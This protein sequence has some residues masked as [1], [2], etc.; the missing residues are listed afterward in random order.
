[1]IK[2]KF[3]LLYSI[4]VLAFLMESCHS[5]QQ[6][7]A[8]TQSNGTSLQISTASTDENTLTATE[9]AAGW[10]LL[11]DGKTNT[12]WRGAYQD[13]FPTQGWKIENG[14]LIVL[15][16]GGAEANNGGDIITT[17][18]YDNFELTLEAKLTPGA[19]SGVKY[20]VTERLPRS[21]GSAIGL[22]FQVL[23]DDLHPDAKKG[24]KG[25][26]T[27]GSLYDLIPAQNK[28]ARP[29]GEWNQ[30]RLVSNHQHV[31]HWLNGTKVVD[32]ERGNPAFR[33]LV[34]DSKYKDYENFGE[35]AKGHILLQDHGDEVH[36]RN[37]KLK[38]L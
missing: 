24:K 14:E 2:I 6:V 28:T 27:V 7:T 8:T 9:R 22:E 10:K 20:F 17:E 37:I 35:A 31:E 4:L 16:S 29:I 11:F 38:P 1:M 32:F 23:D 19:N 3:F 15:K 30:I 12:G 25:N 26:R 5:G 21:P 33:K 13:A 36:Y 34:A 18:Q